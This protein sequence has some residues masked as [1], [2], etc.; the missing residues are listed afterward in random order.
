MLLKYILHSFVCCQQIFIIFRLGNSSEQNKNL[1]LHGVH[2]SLDENRL[3]KKYIMY[4]T[5]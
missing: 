5:E 3:T 1:C 4:Q 2:H